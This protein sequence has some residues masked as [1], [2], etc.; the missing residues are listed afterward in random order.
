MFR[1]LTVGGAVLVAALLLVSQP[2]IGAPPGGSRG[3]GGGGGRSSGGASF[4][5]APSG[6]RTTTGTISRTSSGVTFRTNSGN[7]VHVNPNSNSIHHTGDHHHGDHV[8]VT[9]GFYPYYRHRYPGYYSSY[10]YAPNY[11]SSY[12]SIYGYTPPYSGGGGVTYVE[13]P[14]V[15]QAQEEPQRPPPDGKAHILIVLPTEDA[16]VWFNAA[17]TVQQGTMRTF[18]SPE[19]KPRKEYSYEIKAK[20]KV[21]GKAVEETRTLIV[22][23][24][25]WRTV[26]FT[27]PPEEEVPPPKP[28]DR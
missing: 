11:Y 28:A 12:Y 19:L 23:A 17:K 7:V 10:Y 24:D 27:R 16:E 18:A 21:K 22:S 26:D 2:S 6:A 13:T 1:I 15:D 5:A 9:N 25:D 8:I 14:A 20:W 4:H 3:G